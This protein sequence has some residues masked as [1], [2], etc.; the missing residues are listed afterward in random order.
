MLVII[1]RSLIMDRMQKNPLTAYMRRP[2]LFL[3]LPSGGRFWPEGSLDMPDNGELPVYGLTV[4]DE[5]LIRTPDA[6]FNGRT[7]VDVIKSCVPN[8]IDPWKI[9]AIDLDAILIAIRVAS[10]GEKMTIDVRIPGTEEKEPF[11]IDLRPLLDSIIENTTWESEVKIN[12]D[13]TVYI[14]PVNYKV[15]TDYSI[16][17]FDSSRMLQTLVENSEIPEE[18]RVELAAV[19]M[20][21]IADATMMQITNGIKQINTTNGNTSDP[22]Y[23]AEFLKNVDKEIFSAISTAFRERNDVNNA[24]NVTVSTP[25][26]YVAQGS[27]ETITVPFNFD[28]SSFFV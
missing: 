5:L 8:I 23:I 10:Y 25:P 21:K 3:K 4:K 16:L 9:P 6:L 14:E 11:E 15:L 22:V 20:A 18:Q 2:K 12:N 17:S 26:N 24:R 19:A 13:I 7:T 1:Y 27:P 28:Y